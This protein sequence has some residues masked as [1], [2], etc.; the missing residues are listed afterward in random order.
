MDQQLL[1]VREACRA[2][3]MSRTAIYTY[4]GRE[5]PVVRFGRSVR[6]HRNDLVHFI[7]A[8]RQTFSNVESQPKVQDC[9]RP[10]RKARRG[11]SDGE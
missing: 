11:G 8:Q 2:L 6:I 4:L 3:A 5:L 10:R 7:D 9:D 1:T